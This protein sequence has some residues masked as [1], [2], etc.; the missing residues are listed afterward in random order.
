MNYEDFTMKGWYRNFEKIIYRRLIMDRTPEK[1]EKL[2][3]FVKVTFDFII[4]NI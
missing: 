1:M 3:N 4:I 2:E